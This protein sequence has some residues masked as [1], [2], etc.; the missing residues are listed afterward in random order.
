VPQW[1]AVQGRTYSTVLH[2]DVHYCTVMYSTEQYCTLVDDMANASG[3]PTWSSP[4]TE[5]TLPRPQWQSSLETETH[6]KDLGI[7]V[8]FLFV[9]RASIAGKKETTR[10]EH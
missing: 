3:L 4:S 7:S 2:C 1:G 5:N 10:G 8:C 6:N 9:W